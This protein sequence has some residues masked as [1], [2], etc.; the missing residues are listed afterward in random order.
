[1]QQLKEQATA[2]AYLNSG[3]QLTKEGKLNQAIK[4]YQ[5]ALQLKPDFVPA[6]NHLAKIY[7]S[8]QEFD[9]VITC[10]QRI[11]QLRPDDGTASARLE[12]AILGQQNIQKAKA[13]RQKAQP[14]N[15]FLVLGA[16]KFLHE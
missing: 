13:N 12:K 10:L 5:Q 15:S 4:K 14:L 8:R 11:M 9:Q 3:K 7:E 16:G 2:K 6:L 1:M